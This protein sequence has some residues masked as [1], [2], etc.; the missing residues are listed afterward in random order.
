[1]AN[2]YDQQVRGLLRPTYDEHGWYDSVDHLDPNEAVPILITVLEDTKEE[3]VARRLAALILGR[4]HDERAIPALTRTL[5]ASD[6]I[7][8]GRVADALG[9]FNQL[10]ENVIQELIRGV[11][12]EDNY[13]RERCAKALGKLKRP[14]ALPALVQM[15][16]TDSV[17][18]NREVAEEAIVAITGTV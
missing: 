2:G 4:L 13:F 18:A 17:A 16:A 8:R 9:E 7:L 12:D 1:M 5:H 11:Q 6:R 14:E 15:R 10:G 3:V